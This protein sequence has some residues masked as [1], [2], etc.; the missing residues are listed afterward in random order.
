M[1]DSS[2][3]HSPAI[4][5]IAGTSLSDVDVQRLSHP[6]TGGL[7][8]FSRN[9]QNRHQLS[10][11]CAQIKAVRP[12]A[13][14]AV[15]HEGGRVQRFRTDGFTHLPAM[16]RLGER[17]MAL[18]HQVGESALQA[19]A[20]ARDAGWVLA[21]ELRACGVD[22][23][24]TPVLDLDHG[25]SAVI[26]DRSFSRDPRI[27]SVLAQSLILGLSQAGMS[28]CGKHFPGHGHV[29]ADSHVDVPIDDRTLNDI[30]DDCAKPY[31]WMATMLDS[32]MPAH[33]I[34]SRVDDRP[35]GFSPLWL[36]TILRKQLGFQGAIFS[37][38]LSMQGARSVRGQDL[39]YVTAAE[40]ALNAG[41][42]LVL[43]C[44]Q[45]VPT[46]EGGGKVIDSWLEGLAQGAQNG[47]WRPSIAS[48][49]RRTALIPRGQAMDWGTLI[50][51]P[52]HRA[53]LER[54]SRISASN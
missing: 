7:I 31:R 18:E 8:L 24:F 22:F 45:S 39:D 53:A 41:C 5:D 51:H 29:A 32:I 46:S 27:V 43:L 9:W 15:D 21:S 28:C 17:W 48:E 25:P 16:R 4:I 37:D 35:A 19:C 49:R 52:S 1:P 36:Q 40:L 2:P 42:D 3:V 6:M 20:L 50:A 38:D 33:V 47:R 54:F 26:G 12:D 10:E 14:I 13:L 34:Y 30:L 11:L 23:S 44:N